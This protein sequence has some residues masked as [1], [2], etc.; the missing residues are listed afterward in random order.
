PA[1]GATAC[2]RRSDSP[3]RQS[4]GRGARW[5]AWFVGT[6]AGAAYDPGLGLRKGTVA[7]V[8]RGARGGSN[9]ATTDR[10]STRWHP[11]CPRSRAR[12]RLGGGGL[13]DWPVAWRLASRTTIATRGA[14]AAESPWDR[15]R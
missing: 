15:R 12:A 4:R 10:T 11:G 5:S 1:P 6:P 14:A 13:G 9:A 8:R 3:A 7:F 2:A